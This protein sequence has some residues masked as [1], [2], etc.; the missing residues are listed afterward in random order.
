MAPTAPSPASSPAGRLVGVPPSNIGEQLL[1]LLESKEG[2][3]VGCREFTAHTLVL[4]ARSPVFRAMFSQQNSV[5]V[6]SVGEAA[7]GALLH[8]AYA[9]PLPMTTMAELLAA[10]IGDAAIGARMEAAGL[11]IAAAD[12]YCMERMRLLSLVENMAFI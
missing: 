5:H 4:A 1:R 11:L 9:D 12:R 8:Y 3:D 10:A 6:D 2:A 7:F